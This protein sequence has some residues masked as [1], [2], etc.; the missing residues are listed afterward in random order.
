M[1]EQLLPCPHCGA[2]G[3][4]QKGMGEYWVSCSD[5]CQAMRNKASEAVGAWNAR[6]TPRCQNCWDSRFDGYEKEFPF[7]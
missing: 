4:L 1:D 6:I 2:A 7:G 5:K 3:E